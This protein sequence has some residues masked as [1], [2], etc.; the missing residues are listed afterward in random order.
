LCTAKEMVAKLETPH[1]MEETLCHVYIWQG[2]NNQN[3]QV[4]PKTI[5]P[6]NPWFGEEMGS[7]VNRN[8]SNEEI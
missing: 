4:A 6:E 1:R 5:L 7:E 2:I 3:F 8:F